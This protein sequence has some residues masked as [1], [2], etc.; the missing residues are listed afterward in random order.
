ML[1]PATHRI[2]DMSQAPTQ[3][4][5][6]C[7]RKGNFVALLVA[8]SVDVVVPPNRTHADIAVLLVQACAM[9]G[10]ASQESDSVEAAWC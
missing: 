5:L 1:M 3:Q 2:D 6:V 8:H 4:R 9:E 10:A 7:R